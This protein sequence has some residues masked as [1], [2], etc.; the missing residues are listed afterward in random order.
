MSPKEIKV[1]ETIK[2]IAD[3]APN[4]VP[5]ENVSWDTTMPAAAKDS[6]VTIKQTQT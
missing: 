4:T 2:L 3:T 5:A 6:S 1:G